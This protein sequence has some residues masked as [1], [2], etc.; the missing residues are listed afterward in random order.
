MPHDEI[1]ARPNESP[2]IVD[3]RLRASERRFRS[4]VIGTSQII[5]T[6]NPQGHVAGPLPMWQEFTGQSDEQ[7]QQLGWLDAVHAKDLPRVRENWQRT[8]DEGRLFAIACRLR[9]SDGL[10]RHLT[11][12]AVPV[13]DKGGAIRE[14]IGSGADITEQRR[15]EEELSTRDARFQLVLRGSTDGIWDCDLRTGATYYSPRFRE[16]LG[17]TEQEVEDTLE[18]FQARLHPDDRVRTVEA[19]E[20]HLQRRAPLNIES[21]LRTD[22]G[23]YRWF[24]IRGQALW[25]ARGRAVR[26]AGSISD[27]HKRKAAEEAL[28]RAHT[29]LEQRVAA[30]TEDLARSLERQW[31]YSQQLRE[32][33]EASAA[34]SRA[35]QPAELLETLAH[36]ARR[37]LGARQATARFWLGEEPLVAVAL[38]EAHANENAQAPAGGYLAAP[39]CGRQGDHL[40]VLEVAGQYDGEFTEED[41]FI[42]VHLAQV[43]AAAL[44][45]WHTQQRLQQSNLDLE[46][47]NKELEAF[48]YSVSHDLRAPL[49]AIDGFARIVSED[50]GPQLPAEAAEYL[51]LIRSNTQQMGA[52]VDDLLNFSRLSRQPLVRRQVSVADLV[53]EVFHRLASERQRRHVE[54][55]I[56]DVPDC[57][58]DPSLLRQVWLNLIANALKF[59][60][61]REIARIEVGHQR[62]SDSAE[63]AY[64]VRDNGV[65]FDMRYASKLFGVFQRLHRAEDYEG[66]GVGLATVQRIV[67]R[68]G[69]RVWADARLDGGAC[70]Y[71]S[72]PNENEN[73]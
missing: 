49:R 43:A 32:S 22:A 23:E 50:Y 6:T 4:L 15:L 19:I 72:L 65:G 14:W 7:V 2:T 18:Q 3:E 31:L 63:E 53:R 47:A 27:I 16:L 54:I 73:A 46:A 67:H 13:K 17:S 48:S 70:F 20:G 24:E 58:A 8:V 44:E 1:P 39:L 41:E 11:F 37:I 56:H 28:A 64:Y 51:A 29:E 60:R 45:V 9:R 25:D 34:I 12:R 38:G 55:T 5:W 59:T 66:T 52:L 36:A 35:D 62:A 33:A 10:Y 69:G 57:G 30:R 61:R 42:L 68:H 71:F 26:M 21:R 40:G